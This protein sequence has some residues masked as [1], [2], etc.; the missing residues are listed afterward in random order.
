MKKQL[1]VDAPIP[2]S[3]GGSPQKTAGVPVKDADF[4]NVALAIAN[5]WDATPGITLVWINAPQFRNLVT[6][7]G[8]DLSERLS[9]GG[10]R[11]SQTFN[12]NQ[13]DNL[14]NEA[15]KELRVYIQ[16]KYKTTG[17]EAQYARYGIVKENRSWGLPKDRNKRVESVNLTIYAL[18]KDGFGDL[19]YGTQFWTDIQHGYVIGLKNANAND[20]IIS[21]KVS[22]KN[23]L[24][25]II[26]KTMIALRYVIRGNYPDTYAAEFRKWGWQKEDY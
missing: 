26:Q 20:S 10:D 18:N 25:K 6:N 11:P 1:S 22:S 13:L 5:T 2:N 4:K 19:E 21:G 3:G 9:S 15:V 12:L 8:T 24:K 7:Y 16:N 17:A 14:S 23:E